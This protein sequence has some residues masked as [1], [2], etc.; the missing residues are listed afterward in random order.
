M[1]RDPMAADVRQTLQKHIC[2]NLPPTPGGD[3]V[4]L[5][6]SSPKASDFRFDASIKTAF[7]VIDSALQKHGPRN[8]A[9]I[10][11]DMKG[12]GLFHLA[13]TSLRSIK[14]YCSYLQ[15]GVPMKL[16]AIHVFNTVYF[17]DKILYMVKPFLKSDLV[18]NVSCEKI[19][20]LNF[21]HQISRY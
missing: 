11:F 2:I 13:K 19:K 1:T 16:R 3:L 18:K 4:F 7:M 12:S 20:N 17:I 21:Y 9:I 5:N 15:E 6:R 14:R 10:I 8:G